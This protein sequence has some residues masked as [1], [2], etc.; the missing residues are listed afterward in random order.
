MISRHGPPK[1]AERKMLPSDLSE[2]MHELRQLRKRVRNL[3]ALAAADRGQKVTAKVGIEKS[4]IR[5]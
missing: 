4:R 5:K 2:Q 3:E 1:T